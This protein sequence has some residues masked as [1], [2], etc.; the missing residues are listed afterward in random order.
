MARLLGSGLL[1][2]QCLSVNHIKSGE[3]PKYILECRWALFL[4]VQQIFIEYE[5]YGRHSSEDSAVNEADK[6]ILAFMER[7]IIKRLY[8]ILNY[9]M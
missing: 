1:W 7:W 5:L 4:Y 3:I 8:I 2:S 6:I 9:Y